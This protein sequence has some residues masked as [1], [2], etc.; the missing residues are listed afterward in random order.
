MVDEETESRHGHT[1]DYEDYA[2]F[3]EFLRQGVEDEEIA[4][5]LGRT[6]SALRSRAKYLLPMS[7]DNK[8]LRPSEALNRLR[9]YV[10]T[11]TNDEWLA[12]VFAWH[13]SLGTPLWDGGSDERL[14]TAWSAGS[15]T[16]PALTEELGFREDQVAKRFIHLGLA[17]TTVQLVERLGCTPDG[18]IAI[19]ARL[20]RDA[21][22]ARLWVLTM[23]K[24]SQTV[25]ISLHPNRMEAERT[26]DDLLHNP[27]DKADPSPWHWAIAE[28]VVGEGSVRATEYGAV[29]PTPSAPS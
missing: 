20:A 17:E 5:L 6:K 28:R 3:A 8:D 4:E 26:R 19:R 24:G 13:Q 15:P 25:H 21:T 12:N 7:D 23:N 29:D 27:T 11:K 18:L 10:Q 22:A 1:W 16:L 9:E 2:Q 14:R